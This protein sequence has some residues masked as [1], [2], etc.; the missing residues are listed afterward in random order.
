MN[1]LAVA[2]QALEFEHRDLHWGN[3]LVAPSVQEEARFVIGDRQNIVKLN[4][5]K[6][7]TGHKYDVHTSTIFFE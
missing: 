3:V 7:S 1:A 2:E 6:V 4:G 5:V